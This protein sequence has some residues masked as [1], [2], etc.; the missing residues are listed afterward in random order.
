[1]VDELMTNLL[2]DP[3]PQ[4]RT[5]ILFTN[6]SSWNSIA[7]AVP[8]PYL[9]RDSRDGKPGELGVKTEQLNDPEGPS[10]ALSSLFRK[11]QKRALNDIATQPS[12]FDDPKQAIH[13]VPQKDYENLHR[14]DPNERWTWAEELVKSSH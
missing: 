13:F 7:M 1:M 11:G 4:F 14:F 12:V 6:L 10:S 3:V 8:Q 9:S 2:I 5:A